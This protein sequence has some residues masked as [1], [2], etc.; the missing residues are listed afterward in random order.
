[1][2]LHYGIISAATITDRFLHG[3]LENGDVIEAIGARSLARAKQKA[4]QFQVSKAYGSYEEVYQDPAVEIVYIAVNNGNHVKEIKHALQ[5][6]LHVVCEKPIALSKQDA[7]ELFQ[8]AKEKNCFLM[9][10]Q[11]SVFLPVTQDVLKIIQERSLG[12]L[13]QV[14]LSAS[15]PDPQTAWFHDPTQGG[16]IYASANYTIEYL[17]Y[18]T[19]AKTIRAS[20]MATRDDHGTIDRVSMNFLF[21]DVLV[22][23][24]IS[25][26]GDT[27]HHAI[28]YFEQG[29]LVV[30][31]FWK[32]REYEINTSTIEKKTHP[33]RYEM[34]Y[35]IAH[36]HDCIEQGKLTSEIM[37]PKRSIRCCELVDEMIEQVT[38]E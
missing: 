27:L 16:V 10:A 19:S 34:Q 14:A 25:M 35:E 12:R 36:I 29:Y 24:R 4:E 20:A 23:S 30:P 8:L 7:I 21:D 9:E 15:F 2:K 26:N 18:L 31:E 28:F 5:H 1:M 37:S 38:K 13:H 22:N 32:A 11:K 17:D 6:G 3:I 33:C